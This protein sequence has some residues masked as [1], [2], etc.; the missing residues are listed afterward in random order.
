MVLLKVIVFI[1]VSAAIAWLSRSSLRIRQSHGFL[2]FIAWEM[3]LVL[4]L[5]NIE[6]WF[7]EPFNIHQIISWLLLIISAFLVIYGAYT[8]HKVGKP[9]SSRNDPSLIGIEKTTELV[10]VGPYRYIRHPLYSSLFFLT[11]GVFFKH[12]NVKGAILAVMA[13]FF[14]TMTAQVE[15]SLNIKVFG[16]AYKI[17]MKQ[18]RRFIPF[19]F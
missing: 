19:L 3:I 18:T 10:T 17:Y 5:F 16:S 9:D 8:L 4:I 13:I 6:Y 15:E 14:L 7:R 12:P 2:R 1:I 11:W